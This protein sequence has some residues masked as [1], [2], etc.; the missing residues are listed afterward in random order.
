MTT[1]RTCSKCNQT[2]SIDRFLLRESL[3]SGKSSYRTECKDCI[4]EKVRVRKGLEKNNPRPTDIN[5]KCPICE[6]TEQELKS[7]NKWADRSI[8]CLDH[9]HDT[10]EFRGWI[11]NNCNVAIGRLKDNLQVIKNAVKYMTEFS[12]NKK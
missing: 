11:C 3:A 5:Y 7:G 9:D 4:N 6:K 10:N 2:K 1:H 12:K 8:W